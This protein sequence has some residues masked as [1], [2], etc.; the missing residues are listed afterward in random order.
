MA[1]LASLS[2]AELLE[3]CTPDNLMPYNSI[4]ARV[5]DRSTS[6]SLH[7]VDGVLIRS[8]RVWTGNIDR[9]RRVAELVNDRYTLDAAWLQDQGFEFFDSGAFRYVVDTGDDL[10]LKAPLGQR[11]E[12]QIL[13]ELTQG[14]RFPTVDRTDF[15]L[16][17][18][19][20]ALLQEK[21]T[22]CGRY[23]GY[24]NREVYP[25]TD[26]IPSWVHT[27]PDG[28]QVGWSARRGEWVAYDFNEP[29]RVYG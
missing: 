26:P 12:Y 20:L 18:G 11:G 28:G 10:V 15:Y 14:F 27:L 7:V 6:G 16:P 13:D 9:P 4:P 8:Y 1:T 25:D 19:T 23:S 17:G 22:H 3:L 29:Y 5:S 21:L 2:P 24:Y